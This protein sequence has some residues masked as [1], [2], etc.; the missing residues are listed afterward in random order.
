MLNIV[1]EMKK[2]KETCDFNQ[3][4]EIHLFCIKCFIFV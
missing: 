3:T 2:V 4:R 1:E